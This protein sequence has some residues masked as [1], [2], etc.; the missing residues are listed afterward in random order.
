MNVLILFLSAVEV[1]AEEQ[2]LLDDTRVQFWKTASFF[3]YD[4]QKSTPQ[5][6]FQVK[7]LNVLFFVFEKF[8][9]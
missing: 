7:N 9:C 6:F 3:S 1:L 8:V 2:K 4:G 5:E